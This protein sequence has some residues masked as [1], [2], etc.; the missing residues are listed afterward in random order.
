MALGR[1]NFASF[2]GASRTIVTD[3]NGIEK[4]MIEKVCS[5]VPPP[6]SSTKHL[7]KV[8]KLCES[9]F[10]LLTRIFLVYLKIVTAFLKSRQLSKNA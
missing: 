8:L 6:K 2:Y 3:G 1:E 7:I 10:S 9:A 5:S 4:G